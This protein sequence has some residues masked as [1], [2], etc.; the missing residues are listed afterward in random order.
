MFTKLNIQNNLI[1]FGIPLLMIL[2]LVAV[3]KSSFFIPRISPFV[4]VDFLITIPLVYF[5]LIRKKEISNKTTI[6]VAFL[7][8]AIASII[9]PK[10][11][12]EIIGQIRMILLPLVE[13]FLIGFVIVKA[14]KVIKKVKTTN[15][16]SLDFFDSMQ[17]ACSEILPYGLGSVFAAEISVVYYSLFNWRKKQLKENE[18][19]YHKNSTA[20]SVILGFLLVVVV[21]MFVTHAMMEQGNVKG[22]FVLGVLSIYTALQVIAV[23]RSLAKRPIYI[24][25]EKQQLVL[26]FGII[27]NAVI[28]F[29]EIKEIEVSTK[30]IPEKSLIKYFSPLGSSGGHNV[31]IHFKEKIKFNSFYG[32]SK[33]AVSLALFVDKQNDFKQ[34]IGQHITF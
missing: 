31:V 11:N 34:K 16:N 20:V 4:I 24:D 8:L 32:I 33:S 9:L 26:R 3:V 23:L 25:T 6:T 2:S 5:F 28:P 12:Q 27:A 1:V 29:N 18:Y 14:R 22:S 15:N 10:E 17:L 19:S 30:D 21:E 13:V 7:G